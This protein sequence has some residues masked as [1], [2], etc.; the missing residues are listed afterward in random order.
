MIISSQKNQK[1][2]KCQT[3]IYAFNPFGTCFISETGLYFALE[4]DSSLYHKLMKER[5]KAST[6]EFKTIERNFLPNLLNR[7]S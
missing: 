6:G 3:H 4:L 1:K 7:L 2:K 5:T